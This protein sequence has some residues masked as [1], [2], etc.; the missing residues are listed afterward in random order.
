MGKAP[1]KQNTGSS[2]PGQSWKDKIVVKGYTINAARTNDRNTPKERKPKP[3]LLP[4]SRG[5]GKGS[6]SCRAVRE[7]RKHK[8]T[9]NNPFWGYI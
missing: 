2:E 6:D 8:P 4:S 9:K 5:G 1:A 7:V 3:E